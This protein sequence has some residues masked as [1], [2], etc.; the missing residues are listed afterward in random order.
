MQVTN[1]NIKQVFDISNY[2]E[3]AN[4]NTKRHHLRSF[5]K[6][7]KTTVI[8]LMNWKEESLL[9]PGR[10]LGIINVKNRMQMPGKSKNRTN[11]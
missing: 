10:N 7:L 11:M 8:L 4:K 5:G 2:E 9:T 1:R 3:N 6:Q